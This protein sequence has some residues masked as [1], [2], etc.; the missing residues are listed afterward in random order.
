ML[1]VGLGNP[2]EKYD[3]TRHNLGFLVADK[4][5]SENSA[6]FSKGF[7]GEY[8]EFFMD[9]G[10]HYILKPYTYMN[11]SGESVQPLAAYYKIPVE[12]IIAVHDDLDIEFGRLKLKKGGN[13]GGHKGIR[14]MAQMLGDKD[15]IRLKMGI[16]KDGRRDT[17]GHVLGKFSPQESEKLDE[18]IDIGVKAVVCCIKEG[19]RPAMNVFNTK[20]NADKNVENE[21]EG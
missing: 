15:F 11:L 2:G 12:D 19:I 9:G 17:I 7:K 21:Q 18:F 5:A 14:S 10:K 3:R 4:L 8:A 6:S 16:G 20:K 1:I 13:D